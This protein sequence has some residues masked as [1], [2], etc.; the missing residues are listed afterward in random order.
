MWAGAHL[1]RPR[2]ELLL[3]GA[4]AGPQA[5]RRGV[6]NV[7]DIGGGAARPSRL[8]RRARLGCRRSRPDLDILPVPQLLLIRRSEHAERVGK[9]IPAASPAAAAGGGGR[10]PGGRRG[11]ADA[12]GSNRGC[13]PYGH[14]GT[15]RSPR[16]GWHGGA[17]TNRTRSRDGCGPL[18]WAS[19]DN[20]L[21]L[22]D[23]L[24]LHLHGRLK[25][26]NALESSSHHVFH[27]ASC[28]GEA[29][30]RGTS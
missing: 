2:A 4:R 29:C 26:R 15:S 27:G 7:E 11:G 10:R 1:L 5:A 17:G 22:E 21:E 25:P 13:G 3:L 16:G 12:S 6:A 19:A 14:A 23:P 20:A 28:G 24:L 9:L 18:Q 8:G 30:A